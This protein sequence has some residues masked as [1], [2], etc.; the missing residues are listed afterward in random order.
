MKFESIAIHDNGMAGVVAAVK[1]DHVVGFAGKEIGDFS[2]AFV[3]PLGADD[4]SDFR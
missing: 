2:L 3:T 1:T 4:C